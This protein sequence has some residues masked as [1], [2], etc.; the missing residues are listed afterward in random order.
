MSN[1]EQLTSQLQKIKDIVG[2]VGHPEEVGE[3]AYETVVALLDDA[4]RMVA[5]MSKPQ[6]VPPSITY[7]C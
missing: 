7:S 5:G 1:N 3:H 2:L 4:L 6:P